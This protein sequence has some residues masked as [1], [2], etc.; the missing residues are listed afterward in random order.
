MNRPRQSIVIGREDF[1]LCVAAK[2]SRAAP[3]LDGPAL[4]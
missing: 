1:T 2:I 4:P 3:S